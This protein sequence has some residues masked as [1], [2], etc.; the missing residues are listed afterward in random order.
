MIPGQT[1][2]VMDG[3]QAA[4]AET[5]SP[6]QDESVWLTVSSDDPSSAEGWAALIQ[7]CH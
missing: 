1:L 2:Q 5:L 3:Q 7:H 6:A 4:G